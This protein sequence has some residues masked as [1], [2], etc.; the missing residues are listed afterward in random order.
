MLKVKS[1]IILMALRIC[2]PQAFGHK[3]AR[4]LFQAFTL[5]FNFVVLLPDLKFGRVSEEVTRDGK[6]RIQP[7]LKRIHQPA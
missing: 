4:D 3:W 7:E 6:N 1:K 2:V 5:L